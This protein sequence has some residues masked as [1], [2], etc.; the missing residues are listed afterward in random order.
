[1]IIEEKIRIGMT[2]D[3]CRASWGGPDEIN[4]TTTVYGTTEQ[5]VYGYSYVYFDEKGKITAIQ[6]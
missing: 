2:K 6:N 1:L 3:M 5:W 4:K